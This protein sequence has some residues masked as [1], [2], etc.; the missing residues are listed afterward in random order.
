[1][2]AGRRTVRVTADLDRCIGSGQCVLTEPRVFDQNDH[3]GRVVLLTDDLDAETAPTA[4]LAVETCP[5]QALSVVPTNEDTTY[6]RRT[7]ERES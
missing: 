7:T 2:S 1:M 3:D 5:V 6:T 4:S